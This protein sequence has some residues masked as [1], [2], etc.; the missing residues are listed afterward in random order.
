MSHGCLPVG[1]EVC[2]IEFIFESGFAWRGPRREVSR[3]GWKLLRYFS[4]LFYNEFVSPNDSLLLQTV[5]DLKHWPRSMMALLC[6][7]FMA[8]NNN[9][10]FLNQQLSVDGECVELEILEWLF[11]YTSVL[12]LFKLS[13]K[14]HKQWSLHNNI[15]FTIMPYEVSLPPLVTAQLKAVSP[16]HACL[17]CYMAKVSGVPR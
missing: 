2:F 17:C 5:W 1:C 12:I 10:R 16:T 13:L 4:P 7:R 6:P 11:K 14:R 15:I 8:L 9:I 3:R